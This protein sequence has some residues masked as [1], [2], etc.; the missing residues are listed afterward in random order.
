MRTLIKVVLWFVLI[1]A[2]ARVGNTLLAIETSP[3]LDTAGNMLGAGL[4]GFLCWLGIQKLRTRQENEPGRRP[5]AGPAGKSA[6]ARGAD[7]PPAEPE[8]P[9][10]ARGLWW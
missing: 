6:A 9:R 8:N 1:G 4:V 7:S 5:P 10:P 2:G 3:P